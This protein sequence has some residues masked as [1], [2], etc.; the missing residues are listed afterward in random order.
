MVRRTNKDQP[1][2]EIDT[3]FLKDLQERLNK[4]TAVNTVKKENKPLFV[5]LSTIAIGA[6]G[7]VYR[8]Y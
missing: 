6:F 3:G 5:Q 1:N 2:P 7:S 8:I 4:H